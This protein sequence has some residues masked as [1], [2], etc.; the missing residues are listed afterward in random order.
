L[1]NAS[2]GAGSFVVIATQ[3]KRDREAL[4]AALN[5]EAKYVAF[6]GSR[7]KA[8]TLASTL[9]EQGVSEERLARLSAPAGLD[10]NAIGTHGDRSFHPRRNRGAQTTKLTKRPAGSGN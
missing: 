8:Q 10:I 9:L 2:I 6:V 7:R 3:G 5:S 1:S 4:T